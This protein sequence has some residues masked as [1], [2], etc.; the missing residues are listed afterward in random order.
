M[1]KDPFAYSFAPKLF[2]DRSAWDSYIINGVRSYPTQREGFHRLRK[3]LDKRD[4]VHYQLMDLR[5]NIR[6]LPQHMPSPI[7]V[8][9]DGTITPRQGQGLRRKGRGLKRKEKPKKRGGKGMKRKANKRT[10]RKG[11]G[12]IDWVQGGPALIKGYL[13]VLNGSGIRRTIHGRANTLP[14][15][16]RKARLNRRFF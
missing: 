6:R 16:P 12:I 4:V 8:N 5:D 9:P 3:D 14:P 2:R 7:H 15:P 11:R 10:V 1:P 13:G